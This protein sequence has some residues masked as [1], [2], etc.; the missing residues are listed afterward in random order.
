MRPPSKRADVAS[1]MV[2]RLLGRL[3]LVFSEAV[4][5]VTLANCLTVARRERHLGCQGR[6]QD[7]L[8]SE[9]VSDGDAHEAP[10]A[11][12]GF[13]AKHRGPLATATTF[14]T[15]GASSELLLSD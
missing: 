11:K 9:R 4:G 8:E 10:Q 12:S 13:A 3:L 7:E 5:C 1:I 15:R 6:C 2:M 14:R